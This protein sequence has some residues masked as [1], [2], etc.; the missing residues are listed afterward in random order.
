MHTV[1]PGSLPGN[2][3][4][5][6]GE[7]L[8]GRDAVRQQATDV[9]SPPRDSPEPVRVRRPADLLL[10]VLSLTVVVVVIGSIRALPLGSTELSNDVSHWLQHVP[11]WLSS[12]AAVA[13]GVG[14]FL[15]AILVLVILVRN[16]WRDALNAGVAALTAAAAATVAWIIWRAEGGAVAQRGDPRQEPQ[17]CSWSTP[18]SSRSWS[19]AT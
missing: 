4:P 17:P 11:R 1:M 5:E 9:T 3:R 8:P 19:A 2:R 13:V 10:A 6:G 14:C 12:L 18:R 15:F 7:D 16:Q